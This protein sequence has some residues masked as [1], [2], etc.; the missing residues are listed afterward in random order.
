M[1]RQVCFS[2]VVAVIAA[3]C[4]DADP[5]S[6]RGALDL[7]SR[8]VEAGDAHQLFKVVDERARHAMIS[9]VQDRRA[10]AALVREAYP[11]AE[12]AAALRAL[13]DAAE[14]ADAAGL[15]ARRC[16]AP[17]MAQIRSQLG[18]PVEQTPDGD[19][20]VVRTSRGGTLR[21]HAGS[22]TWW[23]LVWNTEALSRERDRAAQQLRQIESNAEVYRR[24]RA[25]ELSAD[26]EPGS[27]SQGSTPSSG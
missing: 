15:F 2:F 16:T 19:E 10:A 14:V 13:G 27:P 26:S 4:W 5:R 8:A 23:G 1:L 22:D 21:M 7:A 6:V 3:G 9:I 12:Q 11:P 18:A 17:C 25:L 24:R 20:V